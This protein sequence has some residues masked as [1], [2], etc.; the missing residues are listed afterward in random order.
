M[1]LKSLDHEIEDWD[2]WNKY[3]QHRWIFNKLQLA[4]DLGYRVGP[5]PNFT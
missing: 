5:C 1:D 3:S 4:L 2:P